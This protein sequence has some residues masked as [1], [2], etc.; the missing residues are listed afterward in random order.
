MNRGGGGSYVSKIE[1]TNESEVGTL[2]KPATRLV[3]IS[4]ANSLRI[5][6]WAV[7][8]SGSDQIVGEARPA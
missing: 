1:G 5:F 3:E 4:V 7:G 2:P 8:N 6:N